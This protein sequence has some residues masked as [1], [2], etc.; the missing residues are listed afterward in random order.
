MKR[1]ENEYNGKKR[2]RK[3]RQVDA[4]KEK[5]TQKRMNKICQ[6]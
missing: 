3:W 5:K 2:G 1:I 4:N 6:R